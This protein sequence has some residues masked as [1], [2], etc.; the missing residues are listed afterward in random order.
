MSEKEKEAR[1]ALKC[2]YL[3]LPE[4]VA[5]NVEARV[6]AAFEEIKAAN[7]IDGGEEEW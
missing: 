3:E 7:N 1:K 5:T 6:L 4:A 2:F